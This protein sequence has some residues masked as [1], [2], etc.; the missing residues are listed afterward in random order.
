MAKELKRLIVRHLAADLGSLESCV[1]LDF[2][3]LNAEKTLEL[4]AALRKRGVRMAV[5]HNRLARLALRE[6]GAPEG[7]EKLLRGPTALLFGPDGAISAS[8]SV[9]EWK[10][11]NAGLAAV[12]GGLLAGRVIGP[13]EVEGLARIPDPETLRAGAA[14][15][16]LSP[17]GVLANAVSGL[18]SFL[19]GAARSRREDLEKSPPGPSAE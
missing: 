12:K 14:A 3:G 19:H 9:V 2:R 17:L 8:R 6:K 11:K 10:K 1:L 16:L 13:Q 5:V 7:L 18:V 4:R 15:R